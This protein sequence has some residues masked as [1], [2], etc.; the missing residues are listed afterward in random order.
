MTTALEKVPAEEEEVAI[1][2]ITLIKEEEILMILLMIAVAQKKQV[3]FVEANLME[4]K[5]MEVMVFIIL[6]EIIRCLWQML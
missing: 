3:S 5:A 2:L 4:V 1:T 6:E